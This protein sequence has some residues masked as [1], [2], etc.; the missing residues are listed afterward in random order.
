[1]ETI[2]CPSCGAE[3]PVN[4]KHCKL[5]ACAYCNSTLLFN[6]DGVKHIGDQSTLVDIPS[7]FKLGQ[8]FQYR[9]MSFTPYGRVQFDYGDGIWDEWWVLNSSNQ[10]KWISVDEG[11]I[12]IE[13]PASF[14]VSEINSIPPYKQLTIGQK[15]NLGGL[16]LTVTEKDSSTC[17]GVEGQ[18]P[19]IILPGDTFDYAHLSGDKGALLTVEFFGKDV[20]VF[21]GNWIDPFEL[22]A[23]N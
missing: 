14:S 11:D 6:D 1:M 22:K 4:I 23:I 10:G 17:I 12:A 9:T 7:I 16:D 15:I 18:L 3:A 5:M 21:Q 2:H 8:P 19:E 20:N 13:T